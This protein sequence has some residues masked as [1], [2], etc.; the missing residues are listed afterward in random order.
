M[1]EFQ[2]HWMA[3]RTEVEK[4]LKETIGKDKQAVALMPNWIHF[5]D[6]LEEATAKY[7][8]L[9]YKWGKNTNKKEDAMLAQVKAMQAKVDKLTQQLQAKKNNNNGN[10]TNGGKEKKKCY[11]CGSEDHLK[12]NCPHP[13]KQDKEK[14]P[15]AETPSSSTSKWAKPKAG[16]PHEKTINGRKRFW[17]AKC[18]DGK[19][20]WNMSHKTVSHKTKEELDAEAPTVRMANLSCDQTLLPGWF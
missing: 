16:E 10:N 20:R 5:R 15:E 3:R 8:G 13:P 17:C 6:L 11:N 7:V 12:P 1:M 4:F 14:K 9:L 18:N 2:I 19:G